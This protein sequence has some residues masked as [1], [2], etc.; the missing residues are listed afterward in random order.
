[1]WAFVLCVGCASTQLNYNAV[2]ISATIDDVYTRETLNNLSKFID[3]PFAI[4]SQVLMVGGTVQT[5]NTIT[6]SATFPLTAQLAKTGA[7]TP[8]LTTAGAGATL[9]GTNTAQQNYTIAPLNDADTLRNQQALYR[10]AV[11]GTPLAA[12]YRPQKI[13]FQDKFY[14]D[15]YSLQLPHCVLCAAEQGVFKGQQSPKVYE[16]PALPQKWL[17]WDAD[18]RLGQLISRGEQIVD[19][20]RYGNHELLM[21]RGDYDAG[22]LTNFVVF[23]LPNTEP[24]EVFTSVANLTPGT[25]G[26]AKGASVPSSATNFRFSPASRQ[27]PALT[28][29][30]Q[31]QP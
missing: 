9:S 17:Y 6:P 23:T 19:L 24:A 15:P 29:P 1:M 14:D 22:V 7:A 4:P 31:I 21:R 16:N 30:Q 20:G 18:P 10:H 2:E 12:N 27:G 11:F 3:N 13:F 28:I 8:T 26:A 25:P 5:V